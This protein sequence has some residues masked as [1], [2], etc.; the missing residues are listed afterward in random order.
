MDAREEGLIE[1]P[2]SHAYRAVLNLS[3]LSLRLDELDAPAQVSADAREA[4]A[5]AC[6][7]LDQ[8]LH[9]LGLP[10]EIHAAAKRR[11]RQT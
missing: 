1:P 4:L 3:N 2:L 8:D 10:A 6:V 11:Q 5:L 7:R 9:E